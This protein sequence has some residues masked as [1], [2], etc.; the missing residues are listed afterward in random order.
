MLYFKTEKETFSLET[1]QRFFHKPELVSETVKLCTIFD[2]FEYYFL[3]RGLLLTYYDNNFFLF[4][5]QTLEKI[6]FDLSYFLKFRKL[7]R[8]S[9]SE[10][11]VMEISLFD[12]IGKNLGTID[13]IFYKKFSFIRLS[14]KKGYKKEFEPF[15][16]YIK[17]NGYKKFKI[18]DILDLD[19]RD[20]NSRFDKPTY[21]FHK[22]TPLETATVEIFKNELLYV[23]RIYKKVIKDIDVEYLHHYRVIIR[24]L[25]GFLSEIRRLVDADTYEDLSDKLKEIFKITN[26]LRDIDVSL[27]YL[28]EYKQEFVGVKNEICDLIEI[29]ESE[30]G[31]A[32]KYVKEYLKSENFKEAVVYLFEKGAKLTLNK[33]NILA[34]KFA[35]DRIKKIFERDILSKNPKKLKDKGLHKLRI[36][37]KKVRYLIEYFECCIFKEKYLK[38]YKYL[39]KIQDILGKNQDLCFQISFIDRFINMDT[40]KFGHLK[41]IRE[42]LIDEKDKN[43]L[44]FKKVF[45]DIIKKL[46]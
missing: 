9:K 45:T 13:A 32:V 2:T 31:E 43:I 6:E 46:K 40:E 26:D 15:K 41:M 11:R 29:L 39:R 1:L 20:L 10:I 38:N 33:K 36:S 30:R 37:F 22:K 23:N 44:E 12:D 8:L 27:I 34:S 17:G 42:T 3:K 16:D 14:P 25:R 18:Q 21:N 5:L 28:N 35:E 7:Y 19:S 24:R 4:S